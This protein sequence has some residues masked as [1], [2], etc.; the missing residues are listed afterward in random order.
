MIESIDGNVGWCSGPFEE[1]Y[2]S[3]R[4]VLLE[5][6]YKIMGL[7]RPVFGGRGGWI[8][9]NTTHSGWTAIP[10]NLLMKWPGG[11]E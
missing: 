1:G 9:S 11:R 10:H 5:Q 6:A 3:A 4:D 8:P 2:L 7:E